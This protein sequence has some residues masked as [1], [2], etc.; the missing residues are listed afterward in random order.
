MKVHDLRFDGDHQCS[1]DE[2]LGRMGVNV[3]TC[4]SIC[5]TRALLLAFC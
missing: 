3:H 1:F 4:G 2:I 5:V